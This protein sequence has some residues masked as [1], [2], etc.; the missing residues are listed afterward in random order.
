LNP[1]DAIQFSKIGFIKRAKLILRINLSFV[2]PEPVVD[3]G[4]FLYPDAY[5]NCRLQLTSPSRPELYSLPFV[6]AQEKS[7]LF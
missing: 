2:N 6:M 1:T 3:E 5:I 7:S 4:S